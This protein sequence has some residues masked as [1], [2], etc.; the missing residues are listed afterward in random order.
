MKNTIKSNLNFVYFCLNFKRDFITECW[1]DNPDLA[2][3]LNNKFAEIYGTK[4]PSGCVVK[5]VCELTRDNQEKMM[6]WIEDNYTAFA[7]LE[8]PASPVQPL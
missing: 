4:G 8:I 1:K 3:H 6:Q 5:F 2:R 7:D